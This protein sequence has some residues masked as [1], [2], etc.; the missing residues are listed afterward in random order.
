ME[1]ISKCVL[2]NDTKLG[3]ILAQ[4]EK[5]LQDGCLSL[6]RLTFFNQALK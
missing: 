4:L 2:W 3:I 1:I 6:Q 5:G